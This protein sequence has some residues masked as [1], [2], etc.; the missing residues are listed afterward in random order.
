MNFYKVNVKI[1]IL[2][3]VF[4]SFFTMKYYNSNI[5]VSFF[6]QLSFYS[7]IDIKVCQIV[8]FFQTSA[9]NVELFKNLIIIII[10]FS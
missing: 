4:F 1:K 10:I 2:L 7:Y 8:F 3:L 5:L 6:Y 9:T